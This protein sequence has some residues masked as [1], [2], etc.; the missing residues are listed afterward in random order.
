MACSHSYN[1]RQRHRQS[2]DAPCTQQIFLDGSAASQVATQPGLDCI[3]S[4][5][6]HLT[7]TSG[8]PDR[9]MNRMSAAPESAGIRVD[10][11]RTFTIQ[12]TSH[13]QSWSRPIPV[14]EPTSHS[15]LGA[16][17][18]SLQSGGRPMGRLV[19]YKE[20]GRHVFFL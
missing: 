13:S 11:S 1:H 14:L 16:V 2:T 18:A 20:I 3:N 4:H 17:T 7:R 10:R 6:S 9:L 12:P 8:P 5:T 19:H 15:R